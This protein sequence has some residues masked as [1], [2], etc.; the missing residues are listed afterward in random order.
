MS[1]CVHFIQ[2]CF[3]F[4]IKIILTNKKLLSDMNIKKLKTYSKNE[5]IVFLIKG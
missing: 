2:D 1:R 5:I 4:L 3:Y